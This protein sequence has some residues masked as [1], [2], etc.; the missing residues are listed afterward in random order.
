MSQTVSR[1]T[2]D[3]YRQMVTMCNGA[4]RAT[5]SACS[6]Q[7]KKYGFTYNASSVLDMFTM[8]M[9]PFM[10]AEGQDTVACVLVTLGDTV[11]TVSGVF[12]STDVSRA[13]GVEPK[14]SDLQAQLAAKMGCTK[15]VGSVK[16]KVKKV[17]YNREDIKAVLASA[18]ADMVSMVYEQ[19]KSED[20]RQELTCIY[21]N[22]RYGKKKPKDKD[23][24]E[25]TLSVG[26][27][28]K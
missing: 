1:K 16:G 14:A 8:Q 10:R 13:F 23:R 5:F 3:Q 24:V 11:Y 7:L 17:S 26:N 21:K 22:N 4:K 12:S 19:W 28:T 9:H 6:A 27:T 20:G 15:Y 25:I 18:D 2:V